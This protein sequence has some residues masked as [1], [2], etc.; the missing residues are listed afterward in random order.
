M[1]MAEGA[2]KRCRVAIDVVGAP[3]LCELLLPGDAT[4]A[5]ALERA[6]CRLQPRLPDTPI[7]W[8]GAVTGLWGVRCGRNAVP[9]DGDRIELYRPLTSDPRLRRRQRARPARQ[10]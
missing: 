6:R 5:M 1:R 4:I 7:D 2:Q 9:R 8:A 10:P 3:L